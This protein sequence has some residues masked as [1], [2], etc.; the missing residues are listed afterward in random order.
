MTQFAQ[1]CKILDLDWVDAFELTAFS[2][3]PVNFLDF[4]VP[5]LNCVLKSLAANKCYH[6]ASVMPRKDIHAAVGIL[7]LPLT[8]SAKKKLAKVPNAAF[9]FLFHWESAL[10][11]CTLTADRLAAADLVDKPN[12][13]F[14]DAPEESLQHFVDECQCLPADLQQPASNFFFGPNFRML[15]IVELPVNVFRNKLQVSKTS[16]VQV[17]PWRVPLAPTKHLWTDGS[18]QYPIPL[19]DNCILCGCSG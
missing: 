14:C 12:C 10:T 6:T 17:C 1:A 11:G 2:S 19:A 7:D 13:K 18:V 5:H 4:S 15:G 3:D 16:D 9:T 8:L